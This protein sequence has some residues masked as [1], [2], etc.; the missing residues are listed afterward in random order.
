[1][2]KPQQSGWACTKPGVTKHHYYTADGKKLCGYQAQPGPLHFWQRSTSAG[3]RK[4]PDS[5]CSSCE[6]AYSRL[7]KAEQL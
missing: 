4:T 7:P 1:M 2:D 6:L 5:A 3:S